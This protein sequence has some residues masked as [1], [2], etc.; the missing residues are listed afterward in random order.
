[1]RHC[2][3]SLIAFHTHRHRLLTRACPSP[4]QIRQAQWK[5]A[6]SLHKTVITPTSEYPTFLCCRVLWL[7]MC[8]LTIFAEPVLAKKQK[9][10]LSSPRLSRPDWDAS[11]FILLHWGAAEYSSCS[12]F[13]AVL[14]ILLLCHPILWLIPLQRSQ[15]N[16]NV[17]LHKLWFYRIALLNSTYAHAQP[18]HICCLVSRAR[19]APLNAWINA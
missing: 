6:H 11:K 3:L 16:R 2:H 9:L 4:R 13:F 12:T 1:M 10:A 18:R 5:R 19:H 7:R 14:C 8:G 17:A 15:K